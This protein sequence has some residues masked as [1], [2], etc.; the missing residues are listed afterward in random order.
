M[1]VQTSSTIAGIILQ[2]H[3]LNGSS[4]AS[5]ISCFARSVQPSSPGSSEKMSLYSAN[6]AWVATWFAYDHPFRPDK[7]SCWRSTSFLLSIDILVHWI[8]C[9]SSRTSK[10]LGANFTG[11]TT[12]AATTWVTLMPFVIVI[13]TAMRFFTT[14]SSLLLLKSL[15]CM[16]SPHSSHE[17]SGV[18]HL[19]SGPESSHACCFW[20]AQ[21]SF[22]LVL[23][24][25]RKHQL[26]PSLLF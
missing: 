23:S 26:L 12:F 25:T 11:G 17:A 1:C 19:P 16:C 6:K 22:G 20:G 2:N 13:R 8:P 3:S 21:F 15:Q 5:L 4:S 18:C 9:V 24:W 7:S 10:N 14:T